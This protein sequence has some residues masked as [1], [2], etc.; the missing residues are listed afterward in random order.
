MLLLLYF[1]N[2]N[3]L[4]KYVIII[5]L[6]TMFIAALYFP[7]IIALYFIEVYIYLLLTNFS[8]T[9][10]IKVKKI[11]SI[12]IDITADGIEKEDIDLK[13]LL[14]DYSDKFDN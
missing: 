6:L 4:N 11:P 2:T 5:G 3:Y 9:S 10:P 1:T 13:K 12:T 7:P 14:V 8:M